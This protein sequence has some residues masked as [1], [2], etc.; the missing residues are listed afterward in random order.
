MLFYLFLCPW[1]NTFPVN[2]PMPQ[3]IDLS[4]F[5]QENFVEVIRNQEF[6]SFQSEELTKV[7]S[8]DDLNVPNE[9]MVFHA[10]IMWAKHDLAMRKPHLADLLSHVRLPLLSPQVTLNILVIVRQFMKINTGFQGFK[11]QF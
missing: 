5:L 4:S 10:L 3:W 1:S 9:E 7:L 8:S 6:L 2:H 11:I